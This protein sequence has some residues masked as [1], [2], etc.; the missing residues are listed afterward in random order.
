MPSLPMNAEHQL[1]IPKP[2]H[3]A[4]IPIVTPQFQTAEQLFKWEDGRFVTA[5]FIGSVCGLDRLNAVNTNLL[6]QGPA[7]PDLTVQ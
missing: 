5:R 4:R 1:V 2:A 6:I 7:A 3:L